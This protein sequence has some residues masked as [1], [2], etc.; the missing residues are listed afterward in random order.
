MPNPYLRFR[1]KDL[2]LN[3]YLA[4]D[5]TTLANERTFLAYS[6]TALAMLIIGGSCLKLFEDWWMHA[7]GAA[8]LAGAAVLAIY[9]WY[10]FRQVKDDVSVA[11]QTE[12]GES[13][14]PLERAVESSREAA[15]EARDAKGAEDSGDASPDA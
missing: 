1:D 3:D 2:S 10:R 5:R 14:H 15:R 7:I 12:T 9:G 6:R 4:I 8:F 11:L 13:Q